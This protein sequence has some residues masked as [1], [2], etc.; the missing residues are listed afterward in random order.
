[1]IGQSEVTAAAAASNLGVNHTL[2]E[3]DVLLAAARL[4]RKTHFHTNITL[5][6]AFRLAIT[7]H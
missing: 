7:F 1:M 2:L 5:I 4:S 3:E 6:I